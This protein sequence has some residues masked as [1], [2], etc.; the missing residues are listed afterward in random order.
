MIEQKKYDL[1]VWGATG[2]TGQLVCEY[3]ASNY[4]VNYDSDLRWAIAGRNQAKL[5]N[6]RADLIK[7]NNGKG[8][9]SILIGD[10]HK[11]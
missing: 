7:K 8:N 2:F 10:S 9:L 5:E 1:V 6:I 3:L 11:V 4:N